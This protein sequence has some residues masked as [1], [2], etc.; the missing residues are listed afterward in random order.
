MERMDK[1]KDT[2][3]KKDGQVWIHVTCD[4]DRWKPKRLMAADKTW[5]EAERKLTQVT[6]NVAK[7]GL[8]LKNKIHQGKL[9][10]MTIITFRLMTDRMYI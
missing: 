5:N 2:R 8:D 9:T 6:H 4:N 3:I 7:G 1:I 10:I